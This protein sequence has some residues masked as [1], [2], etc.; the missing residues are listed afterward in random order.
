MWS[1]EF[2]GD[3]LDLSL[4]EQLQLR[5]AVMKRKPSLGHREQHEP[6]TEAETQYRQSL[7]TWQE[8]WT[9]SW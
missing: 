2:S 8:V 7:N 4:E 3:E 5:Q 1:G 6:N 9:S